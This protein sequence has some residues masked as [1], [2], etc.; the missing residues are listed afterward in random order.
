MV[1]ALGSLVQDNAVV[2]VDPL[3]GM[4]PDRHCATYVN[5]EFIYRDASHIR[6]NL[7]PDT[8]DAI[9]RMMGLNPVFAASQAQT[10]VSAANAV[11]SPTAGKNN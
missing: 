9:A 11:Q 4:C 5:G 2:F 7:R 1:T 10:R 3:K 8:D 6:R